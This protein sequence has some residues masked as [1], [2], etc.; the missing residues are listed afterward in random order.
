MALIHLTGRASLPM[1]RPLLDAA[2]DRDDHR[3]G[4]SPPLSLGVEEELLLVGEHCRLLPAAER[5]LERCRRGTAAGSAPRSSP[6]RS[7]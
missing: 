1:S 2:A 5:V 7:S 3:F 6:P 4:A